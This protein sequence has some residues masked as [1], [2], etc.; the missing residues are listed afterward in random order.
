MWDNEVKKELVAIGHKIIVAAYHVINNKQVYKEPQL[1]DNP[2]KQ[3]K[4]IRNYLNRL[5]ELGV[6]VGY[7]E[8]KRQEGR[9]F[10]EQQVRT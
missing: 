6:D 5:K 2:R 7:W 10:T 1:H 8:D 3:G 4:Q 9:F